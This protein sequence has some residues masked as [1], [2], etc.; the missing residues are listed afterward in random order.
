MNLDETTEPLVSLRDIVIV[1]LREDLCRIQ[2]RLP[3]IWPACSLFQADLGLD[4]LDL[5]ELVA[6]T[7]QRH[8]LLIS[9]ADIA[10]LISIDAMADH[11]CARKL[12]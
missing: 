5:V 1:Q 11:I 10:T 6:R 8:G 12:A 4:S 2:P 3:Q 7:E 9:D